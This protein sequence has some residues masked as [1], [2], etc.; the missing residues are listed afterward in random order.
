MKKIQ[1]FEQAMCCSTGVCGVGVDP[2][3]I[4]LSTVLNT[5]KKKGIE[6]DRFNLSSAPQ[7]FLNN[8]EVNK[9]INEKGVD[10]LPITVV[11]GEIVITGRYPANEEI[12]KFLDI[13]V[14]SL[15][16]QPKVAKATIG[17]SSGCCS[18]GDCC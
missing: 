12:T 4:R 6:I 11:G 14:S 18:D 3:L 1:I 13:P 5:L 7:E 15:G 17:K 8:K 2:E 9:I 16:S 10:E